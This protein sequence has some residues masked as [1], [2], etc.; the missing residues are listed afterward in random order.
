MR[1]PLVDPVMKGSAVGKAPDW[2]TVCR[3]LMSILLTL[4]LTYTV[5]SEFERKYVTANIRQDAPQYDEDFMASLR[6]DLVERCPDLEEISDALLVILT[7]HYNG[8]SES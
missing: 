3:L 6:A 1:L 8:F 4:H 2:A 5:M 7:P